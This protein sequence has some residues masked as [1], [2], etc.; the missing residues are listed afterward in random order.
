[1]YVCNVCHHRFSRMEHLQRHHRVHTGEKPHPCTFPGC[2]R[3]F[4][5]SDELL[6]HERVH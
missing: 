6:R 3:R 2:E 4:A 5:R 1:P